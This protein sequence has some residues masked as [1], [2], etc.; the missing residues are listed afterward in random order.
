MNRP[1]TITLDGI[2]YMID[3]D[4]ERQSSNIVY[5]VKLPQHLTTDL[6]ASFDIVQKEDGDIPCYGEQQTL[7][8]KGKQIMDV[9]CQHLHKLPPQFKGGK[10][11]KIGEQS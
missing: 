3:I 11:Q 6:P 5:H 7:A 10:N 2:Q 8:E 9:I 4:M 1:I